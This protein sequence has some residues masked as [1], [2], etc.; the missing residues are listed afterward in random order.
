MLS[1]SK[2]LPT[3]KNGQP[4]P[5]P[6]MPG[7]RQ[8]KAAA[9]ATS[10]TL[11]LVHGH[12][13]VN[14]R[15]TTAPETALLGTGTMTMSSAALRS[16]SPTRGVDASGY[17]DLGG[18]YSIRSQS[19]DRTA[20]VHHLPYGPESQ[21]P[22]F[23][24][25]DRKVL[26][27]DAYYTE[28]VYESSAEKERVRKCVIYFYLEDGTIQMV[29]HQ[30]ENSGIPQ[31]AFIRRHQ[32]PKA[33]GGFYAVTDLYVGAEL[34]VYNKVFKIYDCNDST[35]AFLAQDMMLPPDQFMAAAICP[36]GEYNAMLRSKMQRET[37]A[38][39][40]IKRNRRMHPMKMFMEAQL[41]KP[42]SAVDLGSFL[43][44]D[45]KVLR[46]D[47]VCDDT[48]RLYGDQLMFKLH[49]FL[50]DDTMEILQVHTK[51][52]GR[53]LV[54]KLLNRT[55]LPKHPDMPTQGAGESAASEPVDDS[56]FYH[57]T[58]LH[59][60][61]KV[62]VFTRT[63]VILDADPFTRAFFDKQGED[64]G[65]PLALPAGP[66]GNISKAIPPYNGF[67]SEE[68]SLRS[69]YSI[70]PTP[71]R[72][73][74]KKQQDFSG[75]ILRFQITLCSESEE[76][77]GRIF[78]LMFYLEDDTIAV[79]EPPLRNS[80]HIGGNFLARTRIKKEGTEEFYTAA[81]LKLGSTINI[82]TH[83]FI[84]SHTDNYT[85]GWMKDNL[86]IEC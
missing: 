46:F 59:V 58:E 27:F 12:M 2:S 29:E 33:G 61:T 5:L 56:K 79:R 53:D 45:R 39:L 68:D 85:M 15:P 49:Y 11:R 70:R 23:L 14:S 72:K 26:C 76:D 51:N 71:P 64:V 69:V 81:D 30:Q 66:K 73:D 3:L 57:W 84:I 48:E 63:L 82:L 54:P 6:N 7:F 41:G 13:I 78:V 4:A 75:Q 55:R 22:N 32:I 24:K 80:G 86:G 8:N 17:Y 25:F 62:Q 83:K 40:T 21:L 52:N 65:A 43:A 9:A 31:G 77:K 1:G 47:C 35:R 34:Q 50:S 18:R 36:E 28:P 16:T 60:G 10:Q 37:G 19:R 44:N 20:K 67:G 42:Q 74:M 38:D